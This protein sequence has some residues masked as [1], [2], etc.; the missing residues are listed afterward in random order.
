[1]ERDR[2]PWAVDEAA[3]VAF[4][5][6]RALASVVKPGA[7]DAADTLEA[8]RQRVFDLV[9]AIGR[10]EFAPRPHDPGMCRHCAYP[11]VCRKDDAG[12]D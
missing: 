9:D 11:A 6:R 7:R 2:A 8:A 12:D 4:S 3:Y 1:M 5:G 10:G